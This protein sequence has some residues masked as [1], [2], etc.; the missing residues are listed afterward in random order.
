MKLF[1]KIFLILLIGGAISCAETDEPLPDNPLDDF[2]KV[3]SAAVGMAAYKF[4]VYMLEDPFVGYNKIYVD[5]YDST[6]SIRAIDWDLTF[7]PMMTMMT[8]MGSMMHTCPLEQPDYNTEFG[9]YAGAAV[10]IMPSTDMGMWKF[11]IQFENASESANVAFPITVVEKD[12]PAMVSFVSEADETVKYFVALIEPGN[13]DVGIN[14]FEIGIYTKESM[15]S[16]PPAGN[17]TVVIEPEMPSMDHG[18]PDNVNPVD[19]GD[20]HYKGSVNFTMTGLWRVHMEIKNADGQIVTTDSS[21]DI[22]F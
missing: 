15:M 12:N 18:S 10:F 20:G 11:E 6:S 4:D 21:F 8:D 13:P 19:S 17:H 1:N 7:K 22:E 2:V 5:V 14:E 16:F 9:A 3:H